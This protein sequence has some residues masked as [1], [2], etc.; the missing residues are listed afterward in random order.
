MQHH[1]CSLTERAGLRIVTAVAAIFAAV[2]PAAA[3]F[4][5]PVQVTDDDLGEPGIDI[6]S[7]GTIYVNAPVGIG[8]VPGASALF[9]SLDGGTTWVRTDPGT[10]QTMPGGGDS[11]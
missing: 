7:D 9:R 5:L 6:A 3:Q 2:G 4:A 1:A 10:R 11:D 8:N